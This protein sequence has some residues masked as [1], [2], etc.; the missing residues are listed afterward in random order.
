MNSL[1]AGVS[2]ESASD[3]RDLAE[4]SS[5]SV[6]I[7]AAVGPPKASDEGQCERGFF[8]PVILVSMGCRQFFPHSDANDKYAAGSSWLA[9]FRRSFYISADGLA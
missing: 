9:V 2:G 6:A 4:T 8:G 3:G 5:G 1:S 7:Y